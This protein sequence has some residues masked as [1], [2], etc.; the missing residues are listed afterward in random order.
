[1]L[2]QFA[3]LR[4]DKQKPEHRHDHHERQDHAHEIS[5]AGRAG[6]LGKGGG[7]EH[8]LLLNILA[9]CRFARNIAMDCAIATPDLGLFTARGLRAKS[10]AWLQNPRTA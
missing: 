9:Y 7:Y 6:G 2:L 3:L 10:L 8:G 4:A 1:M 5:H